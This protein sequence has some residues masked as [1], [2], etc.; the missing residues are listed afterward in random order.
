METIPS[1]MTIRIPHTIIESGVVVLIER[2]ATEAMQ[3]AQ[4][5]VQDCETVLA[6]LEQP[7]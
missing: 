5:K 7:A 1:N 3:E 2:N 4:T 6:R